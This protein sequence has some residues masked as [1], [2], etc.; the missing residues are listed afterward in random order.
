MTPRREKVAPWER[1]TDGEWHSLREGPPGELKEESVRQYRR[2]WDSMRAWTEINNYRGQ[3][4]RTENGRLLRVRLLP[5]TDIRS[6]L[7]D[8]SRKEIGLSLI[9][10]VELLEY[11]LHLRM[12]GERAP[13]GDET[14]Q[15]FD[16]NAEAFL[17]EIKGLTE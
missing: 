11:A 17:R 9:R 12:H 3:I 1:Y 10:S 6:R 7:R 5:R 13:G 2:H 14:W 4:S 16:R 8:K 15:Q